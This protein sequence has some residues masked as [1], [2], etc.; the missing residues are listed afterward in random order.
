MST[1]LVN[2]DRH[3]LLLCEKPGGLPSEL[4][5]VPAKEGRPGAPFLE[6]G[7]RTLKECLDKGK[8]I[9][10]EQE[11]VLRLAGRE[12]RLRMGLSPSPATEGRTGNA[13]SVSW[14]KTFG[15]SATR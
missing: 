14:I 3:N 5:V 9:Y 1:K 12:V 7:F 4:K 2:V 6:V 11:A 13:T 10:R 15:I 8:Y